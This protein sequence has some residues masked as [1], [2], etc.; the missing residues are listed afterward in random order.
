MAV[1]LQPGGN[2]EKKKK[3]RWKK[4]VRKGLCEHSVCV[5]TVFVF[6]VFPLLARSVRTIP[7]ATSTAK[8]VLPTFFFERHF[9]L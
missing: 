2:G 6:L 8:R 5:D 4:G 7:L 1:V 9:L 3:G